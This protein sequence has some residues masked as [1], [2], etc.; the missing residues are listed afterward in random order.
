METEIATDSTTT[1]KEKPSGTPPAKPGENSPS[2]SAGSSDSS[3]SPSTNTGGSSSGESNTSSSGGASAAPEEMDGEMPEMPECEEGDED[4]EIPE[5]PEGMEGGPGGGS[6]P[7]E[8][9]LDANSSNNWHPA[10]YLGMGAGSVIL[11]MVIMYVCFSN[12][13]HKKSGQTFDKWQKFAIYCGA[14]AVLATGFAVLCYFIPT[15][16]G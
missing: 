14:S 2:S 12:F 13:F 8:M 10:A 4:C 5:M 7:G 11:S 16:I 9:M 1:K 15:W 3:S 6:M